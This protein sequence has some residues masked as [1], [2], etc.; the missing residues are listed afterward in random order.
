MVP[1]GQSPQ[2]WLERLG[3]ANRALRYSLS[4]DVLSYDFHSRSRDPLILDTL[5]R[6]ILFCDEYNL[7]SLREYLGSLFYL[8]QPFLQ[9]PSEA[10]A[11][12]SWAL[13]R[14][15]RRYARLFNK[16]LQAEDR[17]RWD[18]SLIQKGKE[19]LHEAQNL[20]H[21]WGP[22]CLRPDSFFKSFV[23]T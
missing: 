23:F 18:Q 15:S 11:F 8:I 3:R 19:L 21:S 9:E 1:S 5:Y 4:S 22:F 13:M 17:S 6:T 7:L 14:E 20:S 10:V 16:G 2:K 12:E